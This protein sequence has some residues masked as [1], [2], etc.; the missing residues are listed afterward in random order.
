MKRKLT[1][2]MIALLLVMHTFFGVTV[3]QVEAAVDSVESGQMPDVEHAVNTD[4]TSSDTSEA[5]AGTEDGI[6]SSN[7]ITDQ[8]KQDAQQPDPKQEKEGT[9]VGEQAAEPVEPVETEPEAATPAAMEEET[10]TDEE[11]EQPA[12]KGNIL[13][14]MSLLDAAGAVIDSTSNSS[15]RIQADEALQLKYEWV[16]PNNMYQAGDTFTFK[17]PEQFVIYTDIDEPLALEGGEEEVGRFTVDRQGNVVL[18]FNDYVENHSNVTGTLQ[19][20]TELNTEM[21]KGSTEITVVTPVKGG[22]QTVVIQLAPPAAPALEKQGRVEPTNSKL[23]TWTLDMNKGLESFSGAV[24]TDPMPA[25][26]QL[27]NE[28]IQ[29]VQLRVNGDGSTTIGELLDPSRYTVELMQENKGFQIRFNDVN[30]NS[31][32]RI[33]YATQIDDQSSQYTNTAVLTGE[34]MEETSASATVKVQRGALLTKS[35]AK[36]DPVSQTISWTIGY[37]MGN[38]HIPQ[39]S[40]KVSDRFNLSQELIPESLKVYKGTGNEAVD[41]TAY[42]VKR[43]QDENQKNGFDLQF[44]SE[45]DSSYTIKY[46]TKASSR[47]Y[48]NE[49]IINQITTDGGSAQAEQVLRSGVMKKEVAEANY[50][51]KTVTWKVTLNSDKYPMEQV[52]LRD[53][54]PNGGLELLPDSVKMVSLDGKSKLQSPQ[55]FTVVAGA[56]GNRSGFVLRMNPSKTLNATY[57]ITYKTV[58]NSDWK[59]NKTKPEF[60]NKANLDWIQNNESRTAEADAR[61]W[62]DNLTKDNGAKRGSYNASTKEITWDILM[63]YNQKSWSQA[64]V[65]DVLQQGQML[66]PESVKVYEM[67]LSGS[68]NGAG[69]GTEISPDR[70]TIIQPSADNGNEL[71]IQFAEPVNSPYWITFRT[72]MEGQLLTSQVKNKV[73]VFSS[74]TKVAEWAATLTIPHGG[75]YVTK[76]G[77]Q[78]GNKI[79][80]KLNINEGQ[81]T[82]SNARIIDEPSNN[83]ILM[84]DSFHLYSTKVTAGGEISRDNELVRD[85]DYT[86]KLNKDEAG[87]QSFELT[88]VSGISSAY[89]L[90]YQTFISAADKSKVSNKVRMDGERLTTEKR[91]TEQA[92]TVRT[93][94]GSGTGN[95]VTGTLVVTKVD[96]DNPERKLDGATF[97]LYDKAEKRAPMIET[98][99][100]E[101]KVVFSKLLYDDYVLEELTAPEGYDIGEA[102]MDV[103]IDSSIRRTD[104]VK[105][106]IV[107]NKKKEEPP[108]DPGTPVEPDPQP[109]VDPGTSV[110]PDPQSPV[111]P[112]TPVEPIPQTPTEAGTPGIPVPVNPIP[113]I[114]EDEDI[115]LGGIDPD[116]VPSDEGIP[117]SEEPGILETPDSPTQQPPVVIEDDP[118]PQGNPSVGIQPYQPDGGQPSMLPQTGENSKLPF[119][120]GGAILLLLGSS[121]LFRRKA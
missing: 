80:W 11:K 24:I 74:G 105:Q 14:K 100:A 84:S 103:R 75:V 90:E 57:V 37:N 91:E 61:F 52:V 18:T 29:V 21:V 2:I 30:I 119:Y 68:W 20:Q 33:E 27:Q 55:D 48:E 56:D 40:A 120:V 36:Y 58:Y 73:F 8:E 66:I 76:S 62:P 109:P 12:L 64:E 59:V 34:D 110:E 46:Q 70:Y 121:L 15:Q 53:S 47:V 107:S 17:L 42:S 41:G 97:A 67:T 92:I 49:K 102:R 28:S 38:L 78:N 85:R 65:R 86:L 5:A 6:P 77:T 31:A 3:P 22:E 88:F 111:E 81:S 39:A 98:T 94:S 118:I 25:G 108:V 83:Q 7:P 71:R 63:N 69:K 104:H 19:I 44:N 10:I 54:F 116:P 32:Y 43:V 101:G 51:D 112:G 23:I 79:D 87:N 114:I 95:G 60:W 106:M 4:E 96:E 89:V 99:D 93:S 9:Q 45:L 72:S 113:V 115:P 13:T 82:V 35:V 50:R 117:G 16:L 1:M 26:L